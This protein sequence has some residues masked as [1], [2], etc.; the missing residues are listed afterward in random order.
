VGL[1]DARELGYDE[2]LGLPVTLQR[3]HLTAPHEELS[4]VLRDGV[5]YLLA[6][7]LEPGW[8]GHLILDDE[9]RWHAD[10]LE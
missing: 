9:I 7:L 5:R 2:A 1:L 10:L 6:V 3:L 4:A 8:I